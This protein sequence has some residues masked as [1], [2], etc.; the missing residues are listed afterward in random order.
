MKTTATTNN[1]TAN[2]TKQARTNVKIKNEEMPANCVPFEV[3][4]NALKKAVKEHY[5]R[6]A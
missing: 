6:F 5:E 1:K 2:Y 4:A 3:F